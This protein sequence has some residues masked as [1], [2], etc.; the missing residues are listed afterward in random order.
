MVYNKITYD[1]SGYNIIFNVEKYS[2]DNLKTDALILFEIKDTTK[3][4]YEILQMNSKYKVSYNDKSELYLIF[5]GSILIKPVNLNFV[6]I[7][8]V[9]NFK[10][11][12]DYIIETKYLIKCYKI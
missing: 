10:V 4:I 12:K 6:T 9:F 5:E 11:Y 7:P 8:V 3:T 1:F 2:I